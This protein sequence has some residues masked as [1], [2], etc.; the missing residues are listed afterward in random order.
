APRPPGG[1]PDGSGR[2]PGSGRPRGLD[3]G[4]PGS[5]HQ[6]GGLQ[7]GDPSPVGVRPAAPG[8]TWGEQHLGP[9]LVQTAAPDVDPAE[10]E[11]RSDDLLVRDAALPGVLLAI[12]R[13]DPR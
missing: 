4:A 3:R 5:G 6:T 2:L 11:S 13:P 10:A 1:G 9:R 7:L 8:A 12:D